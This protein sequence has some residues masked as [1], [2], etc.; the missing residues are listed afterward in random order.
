MTADK[1]VIFKVLNESEKLSKLGQLSNS[2]SPD[3]IIWKKGSTQKHKL[4][5]CD[6][7]RMK[8]QIQLLKGFPEELIETE[9]LFTFELSGL[10]FFGRATAIQRLKNQIWL[11]ISG[12][13]FKSE[14]RKNFRL[15]TYPHHNVYINF[16]IGKD[17]IRTSNVL[18]IKGSNSE[19]TGLFTNFLNL[20]GEENEDAVEV[21]DPEEY[22][23]FRVL[24][25]SATGIAFQFGS[26][27]KGFF[28]D[29]ETI[30]LNSV[31]EFNKKMITIPELK[32]LYIQNGYALDKSTKV[33]KAG[34]V[35]ENV[36][37]NLDAELSFLI[38]K[39]L[40]SIESEFEGFLK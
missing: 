33:T 38:N 37:T 16:K 22:L 9:V 4:K 20:L 6:F 36:D 25:I 40:R 19:Q 3:I 35:F 11:E 39:T 24:D 12:E 8:S 14:R 23:R 29:T 26:I 17:K 1:N 18:S 7:V 10:S 15:L 21:L 34:A 13:V 2:K 5:V 30:F 32:V 31:L 28:D 27:E